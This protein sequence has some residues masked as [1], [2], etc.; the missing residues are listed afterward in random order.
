M[1]LYIYIYKEVDRLL[2]KPRDSETLEKEL[3]NLISLSSI[4]SIVQLVTTVISKNLYYT[5]G[6]ND[7]SS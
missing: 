6:I 4:N 3:R 5:I 2:Y 7:S 1:R